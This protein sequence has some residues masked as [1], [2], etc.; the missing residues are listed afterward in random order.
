MCWHGRWHTIASCIMHR[1]CMHSL[2]LA[3]KHR[4]RHTTCIMHPSIGTSHRDIGMRGRCY[5]PYP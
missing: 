1:S 5:L 4:C 3:H 2:R